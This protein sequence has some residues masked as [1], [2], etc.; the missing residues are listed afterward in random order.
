MEWQ[1]QGVSAV[2]G[3]DF[4]VA[5]GSI[6]MKDGQL[7]SSIRVYLIDNDIPELTKTFRV[8]LKNPTGGCKFQ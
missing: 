6:N 7:F 2:G 1:T 4:S 8:M 3:K 5:I